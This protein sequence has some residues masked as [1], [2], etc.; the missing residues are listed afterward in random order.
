MEYGTRVKILESKKVHPG[1]WGA[2][3]TYMWTNLQ[4]LIVFIMLDEVAEGAPTGGYGPR[5]HSVALE[6]VEVINE[7][8]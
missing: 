5:F 2:E 6:A 4:G 1:L 3:G 7:K 8:T